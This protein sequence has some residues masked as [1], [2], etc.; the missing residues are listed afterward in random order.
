MGPGRRARRVSGAAPPG[1]PPSLHH[2]DAT[3]RAAIAEAVALLHEHLDQYGGLPWTAAPSSFAGIASSITADGLGVPH[4]VAVLREEVIA[5]RLPL[6]DARFLSFIPAAPAP[7]AIAGDVV[8]SALSFSGEAAFEA[9][10]AVRAENEVLAWLAGLAGL[11]SSAGGT[12]VS[13]GSAGNLN[14]L[15]VARD[16]AR[17]RGV[18]RPGT[19]LVSRHTHA[20]VV[21]AARLLDLDVRVIPVDRL[22][23]PAVRA[24]MTSDVVAVVASAGSTNAGLVD[25]LAGVAMTTSPAGVWLHVDAAYGGAALLVPELRGL[26]AGVE[27]ADSLIV[28]PH[29]WLF[30]PLD[31][32][33]LLFADPTLARRV[34]RQDAPYLDPLTAPDDA[35]P[36]PFAATW[37]PSDY[38]FQLTRRA[39][40]LPLWFALAVHGVDA[41]AAAVRAGVAAAAAAAAQVEATPYLELVLPPELGVV[42]LRRRGWGTAEYAAW[43][44]AR[45]SS[46]EAVVV[47][48]SWDGEPALRMVFLHPRVPDGLVAGLLAS[49]A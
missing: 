11:P 2:W 33:A 41:F 1:G 47:P 13:G 20:S 19:V 3:T 26:F 34:F 39:R 21:V 49:L 22:D 37:N 32:C 5:H 23:G 18:P 27:H 24:A 17:R 9:A 28:D 15:A 29:K 35:P 14:A 43:S 6:D 8:V 31:C 46:G 42:V 4:A 10:G 44:Q 16:V 25:D 38:A 40:G 30:A 36:D 7:A 12:F 48:T 45:L